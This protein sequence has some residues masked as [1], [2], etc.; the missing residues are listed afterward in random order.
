MLYK[1]I[2]Y[3]G[4]AAYATLSRTTFGAN[5]VA[6]ASQNPRTCG[7]AGPAD[8]CTFYCDKENYKT[9]F[10]C[11]SAG[12][13]EIWCDEKK[14]FSGKTITATNTEHLIVNAGSGQQC[15]SQSTFH[16]PDSGIAD[17]NADS[18]SNSPFEKMIV[19]AGSNTQSISIDCTGGDAKGQCDTMVINAESAQSLYI[20]ADKAQVKTITINC[21]EDP[22]TSG[23]HGSPCFI[24]S[25]NKA[26]LQD[27][28][29]HTLNGIPHDFNVD[30]DDDK[31]WSNVVLQ[32]TNIDSNTDVV[33]G[34]ITSNKVNNNVCYNPVTWK[35]TQATTGPTPRP[36]SPSQDPTPRPTPKPTPK[37]TPRPTPKPTT[38]PTATP[39]TSPTPKPT[40][41]PTTSP[42][43]FPTA[44]PSITP[45][46]YPTNVPSITPTRFPSISPTNNPS[47][48]PSKT[49]SISPS[50]GPTTV[51]SA[52][53]SSGPTETYNVVLGVTDDRDMDTSLG[54]TQEGGDKG[55]VVS[56]TEQ[57]FLMVLMIG[58]GALLLTAIIGL[59]IC[60][61][62]L[63]KREKED[64]AVIRII[65][66]TNADTTDHHDA[67]DVNTSPQM[68]HIKHNS[69][70]DM[71][72]IALANPEP[73][74]PFGLASAVQTDSRG[75]QGIMQLDEGLAEDD[76]DDDVLQDINATITVGGPIAIGGN[77]E[78]VISD[79]SWGNELAISGNDMNQD[80]SDD[81]DNMS[82]DDLNVT[83]GQ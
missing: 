4:L 50:S 44:F 31:N 37:P 9:D 52:S 34:D 47:I 36:T 35:P 32:C 60:I 57:D 8:R 48:T 45:T 1:K 46:T 63:T 5:Y 22:I 73:R 51:P 25:W 11:G 17:F 76:D 28:I 40:T 71:S 23:P 43:T 16:L 15:Y 74:H 26:K 79:P 58:I 56:D 67:T 14:C 2:F 21:P 54:N 20:N 70:L 6:Y 38:N 42:S 41:K 39:T 80:L 83:V 59:T 75:V 68:I 82:L 33:D 62:Y 13:C 12:V 24:N 3:A 65:S 64:A 72:Q 19:H 10:D 27:I 49:P 78:V 53:P 55:Q 30:V 18:N 69:T 66:T 29:I 77:D 81:D 7:N 61:R